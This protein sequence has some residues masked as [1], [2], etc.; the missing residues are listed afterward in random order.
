MLDMAG[1]TCENR[2]ERHPRAFPGDWPVLI[3]SQR[4]FHMNL[5]TWNDQGF[6]V[7]AHIEFVA[8]PDAILDP[9]ILREC[10]LAAEK[11]DPW[12]MCDKGGKLLPSMRMPSPAHATGRDVCETDPGRMVETCFFT[13]EPATELSHGQVPG[14][15]GNILSLV[16]RIRVSRPKGIASISVFLSVRTDRCR[17][18]VD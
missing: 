10:L 6:R 16:E 2:L 3:V 14:Y 7:L 4:G 18:L 15:Y 5:L 8:R 1:H 11:I 9:S 13:I 12:R 17:C